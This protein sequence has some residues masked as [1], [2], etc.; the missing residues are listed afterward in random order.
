[1]L[2]NSGPEVGTAKP[3]ITVGALIAIDERGEMPEGC[4]LLPQVQEETKGCH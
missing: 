3:L 4:N 2:L 1:M